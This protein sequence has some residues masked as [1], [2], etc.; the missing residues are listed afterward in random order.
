MTNTINY[1]E[2]GASYNSSAKISKRHRET[3][4]RK[5]AMR[6]RICITIA[7]I[8]TAIIAS[9]V[10]YTFLYHS[11]TKM[12]VADTEIVFVEEGDTL[13]GI[14]KNYN[15]EGMD[16]RKYIDIV[17]EYNNMENVNLMPGDMIEIPIMERYNPLDN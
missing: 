11:A 6:F 7:V 14:V 13:W 9:M 10:T 15:P 3:A 17:C 2:Y 1:Q 4:R 8:L 5:A 16:I 12:V